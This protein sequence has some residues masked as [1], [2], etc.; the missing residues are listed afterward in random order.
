MVS[1]GAYGMMAMNEAFRLEKGKHVSM[2]KNGASTAAQRSKD[3][4]TLDDV[5]AQTKKVFSE[6]N[7][8]NDVNLKNIPG[9]KRS[10]S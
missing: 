10:N 1:Q 2:I 5:I 9:S 7:F 4:Q 6:L 8:E 3:D